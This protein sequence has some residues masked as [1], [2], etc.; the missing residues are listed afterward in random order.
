MEDF[1]RE[2]ASRPWQI[3]LP[4]ENYRYH[5]AS[6]VNG[7][8]IHWLTLSGS[9]LFVAHGVGVPSDQI[10]TSCLDQG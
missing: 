7:S 6:K 10:S 8:Q 9:N 2:N 5:A 3:L 1:L 4:P